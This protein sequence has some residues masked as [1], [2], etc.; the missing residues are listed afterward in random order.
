MIKSAQPY[1]HVILD[2][3]SI[4]VARLPKDKETFLNDGLL[5]DATLMRLQAAGEQLVH[6]RDEFQ[7]YYKAHHTDSWHKLIGL[8]NIIT[9]GYLDI[10]TEEIWKTAPKDIPVFIAELQ[11]LV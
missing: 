3:L 6:I 8:R 5:Q 2:S 7:D 1:I 10:D 9:H 4:V 11:K